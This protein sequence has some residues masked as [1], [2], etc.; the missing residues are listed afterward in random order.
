LSDNLGERLKSL[1]KQKKMT[2]T[3]LAKAIGTSAGYL[4]EIENGTKRPGSDLLISL[5]RE[6]GVSLDDLVGGGASAPMAV[7]E[8]FPEYAVDAEA[9]ETAQKV[10]DEII[11]ELKMYPDLQKEMVLIAAEEFAQLRSLGMPHTLKTRVRRWVQTTKLLLE[12]KAKTEHS[13]RD[14]SGPAGKPRT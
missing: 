5:K 3:Q 14:E 10:V 7:Q 2:Q 12:R 4:S 13:G 6:F 11:P 9:F 8:E 1:R